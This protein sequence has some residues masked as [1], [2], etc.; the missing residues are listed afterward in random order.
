MAVFSERSL[1][2]LETCDSR[3]IRLCMDAIEI[4]D[5]S[6]LHGHRGKALQNSL[7]RSG[8]SRLPH[9]KSKHNKKPSPAVD[10]AP[11]PID[12]ADIKR[13]CVLAGVLKG[14]MRRRDFK[15]VWG[16]DWKTFPDYGHFEIEE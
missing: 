1:G 15:L 8:H 9:P 10:V 2:K 11:H 12:W 14:L 4:I 5:F 6:V 7:V 3:L 16:G 13:F